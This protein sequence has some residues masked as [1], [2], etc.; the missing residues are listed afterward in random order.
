MKTL[1]SLPDIIG[2]HPLIG[3]GALLLLVVGLAFFVRP[4]YWGLQPPHLNALVTM[5]SA[6]FAIIP[7][8]WRRFFL[9]TALIFVAV[10]LVVPDM[11]SVISRVNLSSIASVMAVFSKAA[12]GGRRRNLICFASIVAFNG[13]LVYKLIISSG[14]VFLSSATLFNVAGL[15]WNLLTFSAIWW[16]GNRFRLSREKMSLLSECKVQLVQER[17]KNARKAVLYKLNYIAKGI[18][19]VIAYHIGVM[20]IE[21]GI[22]DQVNKKYLKKALVSFIPTVMWSRQAIAELYRLFRLLLDETWFGLF[23]ARLGVK[24]FEKLVMEMLAA[25]LQV[26]VKVSGGKR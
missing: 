25:A 24:Q 19:D 21:A 3:D 7:L 22:A 16:F 4:A 23:I 8:T 10:T 1:E 26:Q 5:I 12:Y 17:Q 13:G 20:G 6:L 11:F 15:F 9:M 14:A 18:F 2:K